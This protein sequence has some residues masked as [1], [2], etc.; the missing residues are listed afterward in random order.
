MADK[1]D[2]EVCSHQQDVN[3]LIVCCQGHYPKLGCPGSQRQVIEITNTE[4]LVARRHTRA[5][6]VRATTL[7]RPSRIT[8]TGR[9][10]G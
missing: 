5:R 6:A 9:R 10:G 8:E 7:Y 1:L 3:I 4:S 2:Q